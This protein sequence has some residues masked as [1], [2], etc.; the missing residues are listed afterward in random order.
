[1]CRR[2][3]EPLAGDKLGAKSK[4]AKGATRKLYE[5]I[6]LLHADGFITRD[7][8]D[9]AHELRHFGNYGAHAQDDGP[10]LSVAVG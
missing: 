6:D 7:L 8:R 1:M 9:S 3:I 10:A 4:D 2:A 5:L